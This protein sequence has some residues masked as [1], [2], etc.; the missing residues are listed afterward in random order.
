MVD[1]VFRTTQ[2]GFFSRVGNSILGVVV[3]LV[4]VPASVCL[5]CWN[6]YRTVHR[7][8]GLMEA[9]KVVVEV[10]DPF[11]I[12]KSLDQCLVHFTGKATTEET[13]A[14]D[15]FSLSRQAL[16]IE[17]QVEMYQWVEHEE[18]K[19][20]DK[21][22]GGRETITT[23]TYELAWKPDRVESQRFEKKDGHTNPQPRYSSRSLVAQR[24]TIGA[25]VFRPQLISTIQAWQGIQLEK[26]TLLNSISE[27]TRKHFAIQGDRLAYSEDGSLSSEPKMG[28]LR[29]QF[30]VVE[31][32]VVSLL[33]KQNGERLDP[34]R[35]S[36]GETIEDVQ[37]GEISAHG[38]FDSLRLENSIMGW[39]WR[40]VGWLLSCI[41]FALATGPLKAV[42]KIIPFMGSIV[43]AATLALAFLLGTIVSLVTVAMAWIAVRPI[44]GV[45]L[46]VIAALGLY[47]LL[48]RKR[49][50]E[51]PMAVLAE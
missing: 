45:S 18:S 20:R 15:E 32:L 19:T 12:S 29:I 41:G 2:Q 13:L 33:S 36:N 28:D 35:T 22:G 1:Q 40:G 9:E 8:K 34:Y 50:P 5:I 26:E 43:G 49:S 4:L 23:Y 27:S 16:R 17:R 30:R 6:E 38:M 3:G 46:L 47:L 11:E 25:F 44:V 39:I 7:S 42:A 51:L 24:A 31:P 37:V 10:P 48:R 21:L 14:D